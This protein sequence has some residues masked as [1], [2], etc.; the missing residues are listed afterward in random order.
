M[1]D[2]R[3]LSVGYGM[4]T[5]LQGLN[6]TV[7]DGEIL[8]IVGPNGCGKSTLLRTMAR[9]LP[10]LDGEVLL[11]GQPLS[12][13]APRE[14]A[15]LVALLPQS[16]PV[17]DISVET[18]VAHGRFPHLGFPRRLRREDRLAV[19][20]AMA[21][22]GIMAW[23][24][25]PVERLSGGER[26]RVY[27]AMTVAQGAELIL[28]DEPATFLDPH[29]RYALLDLFRTLNGQGRTIVMVLHDLSDALC[30]ADR[31]CVIDGGSIVA[32]GTPEQIYASRILDRVF[33]IASRK[34]CDPELGTGYCFFD[35]GAQP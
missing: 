9:L 21:L 26:Q 35:A 15:R 25:L 8:A 10:P 3:E 19:E 17:P 1:I 33:H 7:C 5:V 31:V 22:T 16:R 29:Q 24:E 13:F 18:L 4:K 27:V 28:L 32:C 6:L 23:R 34:L 20:Q 11:R 12:A 30:Y 2:C 14:L